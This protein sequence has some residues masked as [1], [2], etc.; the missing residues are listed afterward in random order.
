M[1]RRDESRETIETIE[2]IGDHVT[3][4][5]GRGRYRS[6]SKQIRGDFRQNR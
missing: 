3:W 5:K 4:K 2:T 1:K 6:T